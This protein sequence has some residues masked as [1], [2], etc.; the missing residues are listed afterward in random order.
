MTPGPDTVRRSLGVDEAD[1]RA[2]K[3]RRRQERALSFFSAAAISVASFIATYIIARELYWSDQGLNEPDVYPFAAAALA[4]G[5]WRRGPAILLV[6]VAMA[7]AAVGA[8][9]A[10]VL[11]EPEPASASYY[12]V[13]ARDEY[14]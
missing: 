2:L 10:I 9:A 8:A 1:T 7:S 4:T 5:S 12:G 6:T 13:L 11:G 14:A 3:K